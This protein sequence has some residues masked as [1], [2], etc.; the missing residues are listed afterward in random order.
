MT[1][2]TATTMALQVPQ[3]HQ[4]AALTQRGARLEVVARPTPRPG[5]GE[6]LLR[7]DVCAV[8]RADYKGRD[9]DFPPNPQFPTVLG[10]DAGGVVVAVGPG[11]ARLRPGDR[12]VA[13]AGPFF[14][15]GDPNTGA[16][17]QYTL[18]DAPN[19]ARVPPDI[20]LADAAALPVATF[21]AITALTTILGLPLTAVGA[22]AHGL[23][24]WGAASSVGTVAVQAARSLGLRVYATAAPAN[25][26]Y[27]ATLG[28]HTLV[29]YSDPDAA[30]A[31]ILAAA[32]RDGVILTQAICTVAAAL[33]PTVAILAAL[34]SDGVTDAGATASRAK[35]ASVDM[36]PADFD[37]AAASAAAQGVDVAFVMPPLDQATRVP[38]MARCFQ[39]LEDNLAS[40]ALVPSPP[41]R[42]VGR[43]LDAINQALDVLREGVSC[44]KL[45]V[46][47]DHESST[48]L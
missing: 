39:W 40:G 2:P 28:A 46:T 43:G 20:A 24:V 18:V 47:L 48:T 45:V 14:R 17:Q 8:N 33:A 29:D 11:E 30:V 23:L 4:A 37:A 22:H 9:A 27:L 25:H 42:V 3:Q 1:A 19:A 38:H 21:T 44:A 32:R 34:R 7:V 5:P 12:V 16:F 10:G 31:E 6:L 41:A 13:W 35:V 26:A 15:G 36:P